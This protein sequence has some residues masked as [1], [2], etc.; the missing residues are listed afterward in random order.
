MEFMRRGGPADSA[1]IRLVNQDSVTDLGSVHGMQGAKA[2]KQLRH[3]RG[4]RCGRSRC[5]KKYCEC[6]AAGVQCGANCECTDCGN[7]PGSEE[8]R[9]IL[10]QQAKTEAQQR[11]ALQLNH[12]NSEQPHQHV[13]SEI[14][15]YDQCRLYANLP[16]IRPV[17]I[18]KHQVECAKIFGYNFDF[19]F[20]KIP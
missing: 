17:N 16:A 4:C 9:N 10:E 8:L 13:Y 15:E 1:Q 14:D 12:Q 11:Y 18:K 7:F 5:L 6:F 19:K 2:A 20:C 3:A